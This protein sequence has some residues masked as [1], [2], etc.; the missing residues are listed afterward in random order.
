MSCELE[1]IFLFILNIVLF[2]SHLVLHSIHPVRYIE[3]FSFCP[4]YVLT[5]FH[6]VYLW[7]HLFAFLL[8]HKLFSPPVHWSQFIYLLFN[9]SIE[10]LIWHF[11]FLFL[12]FL[13]SPFPIYLV[14]FV[15]LILLYQNNKNDPLLVLYLKTLNL[16]FLL[17]SRWFF[18]PV[19]LLIFDCK[20]LLI[21]FNP[22]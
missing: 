19:C 21:D 11:I 12:K 5:F 16:L 20:L 13:W 15:L 1:I 14:I 18:S 17:T 7:T 10:L 4:F 6:I 22:G 3:T 2:Y 8:F 9:P